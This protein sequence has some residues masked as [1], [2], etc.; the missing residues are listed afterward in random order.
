MPRKISIT[1]KKARPE[2]KYITGQTKD[3]AVA[4]VSRFRPAFEKTALH[5]KEMLPTKK[6]LGSNG[7]PS[8][9]DIQSLQSFC[10]SIVAPDGIE[11]VKQY[12]PK[13]FAFGVG[14][15][16]GGLDSYME[17]EVVSGFDVASLLKEPRILDAAAMQYAQSS[18]YLATVKKDS[19]EISSFLEQLLI[20]LQD[21]EN[22]VTIA[23]RTA[24]KLEQ[25]PSQWVTLA[26]SEMADALAQGSM[27]EARRLGAD[28]VFVPS[29][30]D[31]SEACQRL[32]E[33]R[34]FGR[35]WLQ[36]QSNVGKKSK[37]WGAA[38]PCH[39]NCRHHL[40][41]ASRSLLAMVRKQI[42]SDTIPV[43]GIKVD[44]KPP[45]QR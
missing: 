25:N 26:R 7:I 38:L 35:D 2:E 45:S 19:N 42:G 36:G 22:P 10:A 37:D 11:A 21:G 39:P 16:S 30:P 8:F 41:P 20:G 34:L 32:I 1:I 13:G 12:I 5:I 29:H 24:D 44:Y 23:R 3:F 27:D 28:Y 9:E 31:A 6:A 17:G 18:S 33:G 4:L 43:T 14:Q 15:F 40:L